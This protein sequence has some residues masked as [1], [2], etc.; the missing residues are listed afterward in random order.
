[1]ADRAGYSVLAED[2]PRGIDVGFDKGLRVVPQAVG[3][4]LFAGFAACG[5]VLALSL[6]TVPWDATSPIAIILALVS[7]WLT[8]VSAASLA[9]GCRVTHLGLLCSMFAS[10][11]SVTE[12][13][14][15]LMPAMVGFVLAGDY[16]WVFMLFFLVALP[17]MAAPLSVRRMSETLWQDVNWSM[18]DS[19]L[20]TFGVPQSAWFLSHVENFRHDRYAI[21]STFARN[22]T[23]IEGLPSVRHFVLDKASGRMAA[24]KETGWVEEMLTREGYDVEHIEDRA[25]VVRWYEYPSPTEDNGTL[26]FQAPPARGISADEYYG[27]I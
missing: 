9:G 19:T 27:R 1:M 25:K 17:V 22:D 12:L 16:F 5:I 2:L 18:M 14:R 8:A 13:T 3:Y 23:Q 7:L 6:G 21:V 20:Y 10:V 24:V 11:L 26:A 15:T 4:V